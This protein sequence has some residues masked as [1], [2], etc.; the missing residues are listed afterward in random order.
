MSHASRFLY[1][2]LNIAYG[3]SIGAAKALG[4]HQ[5]NAWTDRPSTALLMVGAVVIFG[6]AYVATV[7]LRGQR[8]ALR[9]VV[10]VAASAASVYT[11]S[12]LAVSAPGW[13][14]VWT[15]AALVGLATGLLQP[16]PLRR[17]VPA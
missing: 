7:T 9:G 6:A 1:L 13:V 2:I 5:H 4:V 14:L 8:P 12:T 15:G 3:A 10:A 16:L 17:R 11:L